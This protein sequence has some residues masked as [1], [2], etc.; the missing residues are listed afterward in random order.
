MLF[1]LDNVKPC[2]KRAKCSFRLCHFASHGSIICQSVQGKITYITENVV[3]SATNSLN[4]IYCLYLQTPFFIRNEP[5]VKLKETFF[6]ANHSLFYFF[7]FKNVFIAT[8]IELT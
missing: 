2:N 6:F 8:Q 5:A 4:W 7:F 1:A 3:L